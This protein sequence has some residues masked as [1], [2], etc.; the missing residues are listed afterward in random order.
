MLVEYVAK[1]KFKQVEKG[2]S[3]LM[4]LLNTTNPVYI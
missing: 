2:Y 3:R 4:W 1:S